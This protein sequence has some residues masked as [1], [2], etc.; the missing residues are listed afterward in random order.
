[1]SGL[2]TP[3]TLSI[4]LA[5]PFD[6]CAM[7]VLGEQGGNKRNQEER[8]KKKEKKAMEKHHE[9]KAH[10]VFYRAHKK[11]R[12]Q[13][14]IASTGLALRCTGADGIRIGYINVHRPWNKR[15]R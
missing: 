11:E 10:R 15:R 1:M 5:L 14:R 2:H 3:K 8:R 4:Y 7:Y 13:A 6:L 12:K 9:Q